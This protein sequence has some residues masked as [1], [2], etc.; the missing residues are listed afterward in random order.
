MSTPLRNVK[1]FMRADSPMSRALNLSTSLDESL[2]SNTC[3]FSLI[4]SGF[5]LFGMAAMPFSMFNRSSIWAG[6]LLC[7]FAISNKVG[8]S[9]ELGAVIPNSFT[10]PRDPRGEYAVTVMSL[11]WQNLTWDIN[12]EYL[13]CARARVCMS[14]CEHVYFKESLHL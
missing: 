2:K 1:L 13:Q 5:V 7:V 8:F 4:L 10:T 14:V 6:V 3:M 9:N 12:M 11:L